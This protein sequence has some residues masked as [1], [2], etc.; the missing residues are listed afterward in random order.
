[1][2]NKIFE[3]MFALESNHWWFVARRKIIFSTINNLDLPRNIR[4]L[5][6][7]CGNGDNLSLLSHFG[8]LVAFEKNE[9][10]FRRARS[11]KIGQIAKLIM[12]RAKAKHIIDSNKMPTTFN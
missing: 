10:A 3:K 9:E 12:L 7:G 5:D 8:D 2:E 6:A 11:K 1:M 4:I